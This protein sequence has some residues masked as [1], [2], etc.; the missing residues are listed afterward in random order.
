MMTKVE[1]SGMEFFA[2][3]GCLETEKRDGNSFCVDVEYSYDAAGAAL[4]D[5]LSQAVDYSAVY[6]I[7]RR[8]MAVPSN[9]LENVAFRIRTAIEAEIPEAMDVRVCVAKRNP[10]VGGSC[11]WSKVSL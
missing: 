5:D 2:Y 3:H 11:K 4:S 8:E 6:E 7:V 10:P 9:L 1:L